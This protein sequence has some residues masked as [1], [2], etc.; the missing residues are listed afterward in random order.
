VARADLSYEE[1]IDYRPAVAEP[2][3]FD[4]FWD[5][6]ITE[7]RSFDLDVQLQPVDTPYRTVD[8]YDLSFCGFAG[9][10]IKA[11]LSN[12]RHDQGPRPAVVEFVGYNGGRDVPGA[13]LFWASA[14]YTH[15]L[16]DTRGQGSAWGGGG[17]TE[18]PPWIW[19]ARARLLD[20]GR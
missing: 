14:G 12:P 10:R 11:W 3:D 5:D 17:E 19:T 1:L 20:S 8:I 9:D 2:P 16:V 15:L 7:A 4:A 6:T 13:S 18:G